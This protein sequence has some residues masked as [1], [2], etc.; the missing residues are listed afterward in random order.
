[1]KTTCYYESP[2]VGTLE[3]K[4]D[5]VG[6]SEISFVSHDHQLPEA[7]HDNRLMECLIKELDLYFAGELQSFTV[8]LHIPEVGQFTEK[9]WS[10]LRKIP[11][12]KTTSYGEIATEIGCERAARAVG[13]A[14]GKNVLP[15]VIPCHRVIHADGGL[16]GYSSGLEIKRR[17]LELEGVRISKDS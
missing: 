13:T 2:L 5:D 1:M 17:L 8:P 3:L 16:G 14:N 10:A 4:V 7:L 6:V 11:Y 9:V 15:I 12:G